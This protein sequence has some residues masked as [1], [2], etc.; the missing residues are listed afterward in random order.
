MSECVSNNINVSIK[1]ISYEGKIPPN[2]SNKTITTIQQDRQERLKHTEQVLKKLKEHQHQLSREDI[3][4]VLK[5]M[6]SHHV[7]NGS[8]LGSICA[9][10]ITKGRSNSEEPH[11][12]MSGLIW[13]VKKKEMYYTV[14]HP[15]SSEWR[16]ISFQ[17]N[18]SSNSKR[19]VMNDSHV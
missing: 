13:D 6:L 2:K 10:G 19:R 17:K 1:D 7:G 9:H 5:D 8:E 4:N 14:G 12:T 16:K 11:E 18:F 15:C 3:L